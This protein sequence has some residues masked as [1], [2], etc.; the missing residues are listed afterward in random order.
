MYEK[1]NNDTTALCIIVKDEI[2]ILPSQY[3]YI[4]KR[5][6]CT[7]NCNEKCAYIEREEKMDR[8]I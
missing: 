8:G 3:I 2:G 5:G 6:I 1:K 4:Y 7:R